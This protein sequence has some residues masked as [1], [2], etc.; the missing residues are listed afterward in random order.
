MPNHPGEPQRPL[1]NRLMWF[2]ALWLGGVCAVG[3]LALLIRSVLL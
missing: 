3:L 2:V 1:P